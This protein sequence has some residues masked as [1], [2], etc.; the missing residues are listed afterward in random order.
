METYEALLKSQ[1]KQ[2]E[3]AVEVDGGWEA[4]GELLFG[5]LMCM[6]IQFCPMT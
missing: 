5:L 4:D 1:L 6:F 3:E 2:L